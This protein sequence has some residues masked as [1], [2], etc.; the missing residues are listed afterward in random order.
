MHLTR[1]LPIVGLFAVAACQTAPAPPSGFLASYDA[2]EAPGFSLRAS[3]AQ[4]RD[5]SALDRLERVH[6]Q[7]AVLTEGA[8]EALD[9]GE[10]DAVLREVDRRLCFA[11][12]RRFTLVPEPSE[13][14]GVVRTAV[15]RIRPT[16][17]VASAVS[18]VAG[19]FASV[20]LLDI[21][22]P[23]TT[24]GLAVE[25][26]LLGPDGAQLAAVTWNRN[27][28]VIGREGSSLSR[29]GD[30]VQLTGAAGGTVERAFS[31]E[32]RERRPVDDPDPCAAYGPRRNPPR[33][34]ASKLFGFAT[35]LY[36]PEV[37]GLARPADA[38]PTP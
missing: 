16:G 23:G 1:I 34:V 24:G 15:T 29:I 3:V 2:L 6:L 33:W 8:G 13:D 9:Q 11:L 21:R 17:R 28:T 27:A 31:T 30:A 18:A 35:G 36:Q 5:E 32:A 7:P 25:S 14:A 12:S 22:I 37:E 38:E 20:P 4:R 10:R 19:H 26:E